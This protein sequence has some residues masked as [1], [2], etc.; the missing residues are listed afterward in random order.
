MAYYRGDY[1]PGRRARGDY[2][3]GHGRGD[4]FWGAVWRGIQTVGKI[5]LGIPL[6]GGA[7]P[8]G[9]AGSII[10]ATPPTFPSSQLTIMQPPA[11][12]MPRMRMP[13]ALPAERPPA[14]RD[15]QLLPNGEVLVRRKRRTMN[16]GNVKALRRSIRRVVSFGKL[17]ANARSAVGKAA[18]QLQYGGRR[19]G[20][21][22]GTA[23]A[24]A[25]AR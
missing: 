19:R 7:A 22:R 23:I 9:A 10:G 15:I 16:A 21:S 1:Y 24:S 12:P 17:C 11:F 20:A 3:R 2:Y 14:G 8:T 6:G 18:T 5:A 4:P 13:P 25:R